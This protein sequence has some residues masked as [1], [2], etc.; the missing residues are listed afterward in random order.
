MKANGA[1]FIML[2]LL[3]CKKPMHIPSFKDNRLKL[4]NLTKL[5]IKNL[6][7]IDFLLDK[8][9]NITI[10]LVEYKTYNYVV[11]INV[12]MKFLIK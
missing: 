7:F 2:I 10:S 4:Y 12:I 8:V 5:S 9:S 3:N 11:E 1:L 6:R